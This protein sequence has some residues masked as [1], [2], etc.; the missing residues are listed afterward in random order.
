MAD[1]KRPRRAATVAVKKPEELP[2]EVAQVAGRTA[3]KTR[4]SGTKPQAAKARIVARLKRLH[5]MD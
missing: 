3:E 4:T 2:R 5:P 1:V